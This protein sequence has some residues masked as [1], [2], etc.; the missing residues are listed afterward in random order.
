MDDRPAKQEPET[1]VGG[2]GYCVSDATALAG[3]L[4]GHRKAEIS[5]LVSIRQRIMLFLR[6]ESLLRVPLRPHRSQVLLLLLFQPLL[7]VGFR[8][9][10]RRFLN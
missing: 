9:L 4:C 1:D 8:T 10:E 2:R 7:L 5:T 6:N 3:M